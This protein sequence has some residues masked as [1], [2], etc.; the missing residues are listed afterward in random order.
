M[1]YVI[2]TSGLIA[3]LVAPLA[4]SKSQGLN[5]EP[6]APTIAQG[7]FIVLS[8]DGAPVPGAGIL[9]TMPPGQV[10]SHFAGTTDAN[11]EWKFGWNDGAR[12]ADGRHGGWGRFTLSVTPPPGSPL[13]PVERVDS[14]YFWA[15]G[16]SGYYGGKEI[17]HE[18]VLKVT[19]QP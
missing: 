13:R 14:V 9:V 3:S 7:R 16:E 19:L 18:S 15:T 11:G 5:S 6:Q 2:L 1:K 12:S 8:P 10:A 17:I 4:C